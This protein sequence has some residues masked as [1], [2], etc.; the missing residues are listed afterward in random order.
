MVIIAHLLVVR[1][2]QTGLICAIRLGLLL[3][4]IEIA[5]E[6]GIDFD[7]FGSVGHGIFRNAY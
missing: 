1:Q 7:R 6:I 4:G 3:F 5:I 2:F